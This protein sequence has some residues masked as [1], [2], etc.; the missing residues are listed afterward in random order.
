MATDHKPP[1]RRKPSW[2]DTLLLILGNTLPIILSA[3]LR[4]SADE[5]PAQIVVKSEPGFGNLKIS[6]RPHVS[7][8]LLE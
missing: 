2:Q 7:G 3:L 5:A 6:T 4:P 8:E 1:T